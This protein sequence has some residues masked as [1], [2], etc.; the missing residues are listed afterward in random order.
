MSSINN[1]LFNDLFGAGDNNASARQQSAFAQ[2]YADYLQQQMQ[3]MNL[4]MQQNNYANQLYNGALNNG[5]WNPSSQIHHNPNQAPRRGNPGNHALPSW[6]I[7]YGIGTLSLA[8]TGRGGNF[9]PARDV[10]SE[11]IRAGEVIGYRAWTLVGGSTPRLASIS[12]N[13]LWNPCVIMEGDVNEF[14]IFAFK[15]RARNWQEWSMYNSTEY[16]IGTVWMWGEIVE[17]E[18][19]YRSTRASVRSIDHITGISDKGEPAYKAG[20]WERFFFGTSR[21]R[22]PQPSPLEKKLAELRAVY[23]VEKVAE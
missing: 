8:G 14:G 12:A 21:N 2:A 9:T 22:S 11:G 10:P 4:Q 5:Y 23:G 15:D 20:F 16:V 18:H 6:L 1:D 19:G 17:H 7:S 3:L 13:K